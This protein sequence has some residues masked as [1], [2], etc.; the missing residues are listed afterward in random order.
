MVGC[1]LWVQACSMRKPVA[2]GRPVLE[3]NYAAAILVLAL[4]TLYMQP[5]PLAPFWTGTHLRQGLID[6]ES[7]GYGLL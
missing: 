1:V 5:C 7:G 6:Q 4:E 2:Y 3:L